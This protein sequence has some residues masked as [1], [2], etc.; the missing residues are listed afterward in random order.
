MRARAPASLLAAF[1]ATLGA[2]EP[3]PQETRFDAAHARVEFE[4]A[5][6]WLLRRHGHF[7]HIEGRLLTDAQ[8]GT[9]TLQVRIRVD[10]V[11][12]KDPDHVRL[13]LSPEFFD[14]AHHPW[15]EFES[16]PFALEDAG[17]A[18]LPGHLSVRGVRRKVRFELEREACTGA[19]AVACE[20]SVSG[21]LRRSRYGM[22]GYRRTL[23]DRVQ[24]RIV[25]RLGAAADDR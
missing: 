1:C 21:S 9:A 7:E 16:E 20:V 23:S 24:L 3:P 12:M 6:L 5:A 15:I 11:R 19:D 18:A 13:L 17:E 8:A 4:I 14:A 22:T 2:A 10:S 25:A